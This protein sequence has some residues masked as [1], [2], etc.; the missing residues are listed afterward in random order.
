MQ[1]INVEK[2]RKI[3]PYF[4]YKR[5]QFNNQTALK[6]TFVEKISAGFNY[7]TKRL[8]VQCSAAYIDFSNVLH[9]AWPFTVEMIDNTVGRMRQDLPTPIELFTSPGSLGDQ[10]ASTDFALLPGRSRN[11]GTVYFTMFSPAD[12]TAFRVNALANQILSSKELNY[13]YPSGDVIRVDI[14]TTNVP[15]DGSATYFDL[16]VDGYYIPDRELDY[17]KGAVNE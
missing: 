4:L 12:F 15:A 2:M 14:S 6:Q 7:Y 13:L 16:L 17:W 1:K 11:P 5:F 8:Y 10:M 9:W 3:Q